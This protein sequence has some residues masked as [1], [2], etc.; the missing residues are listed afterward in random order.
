MAGYNSLIAPAAVSTRSQNASACRSCSGGG[1]D[2]GAARCG[3]VR[4]RL[5]ARII[6]NGA[7]L[8]I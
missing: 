2:G 8:S 5:S 3:V 7:A 4:W 1:G 6:I